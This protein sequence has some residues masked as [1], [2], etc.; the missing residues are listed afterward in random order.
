MTCDLSLL[1]RPGGFTLTDR[2]LALCGFAVG[3]RVLDIGCGSGATVHH[4]RERHGLEA[5][6]ID[7]EPGRTSEFLLRGAALALPFRDAAFDGVLLECSLSLMDDPEAVLRE[8][9][10]ILKPAGRILLTDLYARG[11]PA[12]LQ[13]CLGI[14]ER[15]ETLEA[16]VSSQGF[17]HLHFEDHSEPLR[18][19][20]GQM[21]LDRGLAV[22]CAELGA[23]AQALRAV[24][25]GYALLVARKDAP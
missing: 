1:R 22:F 15:R 24:R 19:L 3:S 13:G 14:V 10:R 16:W 18:A 4:L 2:G 20:W 7:L 17:P 11:E 21:V 25:C 5:W 23:D 12:R 6:G 9:H 8:C